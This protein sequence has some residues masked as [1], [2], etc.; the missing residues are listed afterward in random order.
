MAS[1]TLTGDTWTGTDWYQSNVSAEFVTN[2]ENAFEAKTTYASF[3]TYW[4]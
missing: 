2:P 3:N 1:S 4:R